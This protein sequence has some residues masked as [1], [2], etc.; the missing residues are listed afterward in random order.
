MAAPM[1][2]FMNLI[3]ILIPALIYQQV[4]DYYRH[5]VEL[6]AGGGSAAGVSAPTQQPFNLKLTIGIDGSFMIVNAKALSPADGL[7]SQGPG[8]LLAPLAGGT[9]DYVHLRVLLS[10]EKKLRLGGQPA[11]TFPDADQITV[12]APQDMEYQ[13]IISA[14]DYLRFEA[15]PPGSDLADA[16]EMFTVISLSPGSIG[17]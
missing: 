15:P 16:K 14:L 6:P 4:Q 1:H 10:K 9:P 2:I 13:R 12:S 8:L 7:V 3:C 11:A 5:D 17:G